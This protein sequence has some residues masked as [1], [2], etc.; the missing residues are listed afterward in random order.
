MRQDHFNRLKSSIQEAGRIQRGEVKASRVFHYSPLDIRKIRGR[1][2]KSQAEFAALLGLS[3][4]TL[5]EWEQGRRKPSGPARML[6]M[7]ADRHPEVIADT[8]GA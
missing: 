2:H 5:Q 4:N 3:V 7:V 6:L 1:F 8:L